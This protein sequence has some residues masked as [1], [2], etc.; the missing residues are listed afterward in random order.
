MN[1]LKTCSAFG[2]RQRPQNNCVEPR[3]MAG[4][5]FTATVQGQRNLSFSY[6]FETVAV[7]GSPP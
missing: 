5:G 1:E 3:A 4:V 7:S 6:P 2:S